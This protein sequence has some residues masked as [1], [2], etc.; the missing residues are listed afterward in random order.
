MACAG[1]CIRN[2]WSPARAWAV[3]VRT[4]RLHV[5]LA[6]WMPADCARPA[7]RRSS[8]ARRTAAGRNTE[9]LA[10]WR[11]FR[12]RVGNWLLGLLAPALL[13]LLAVTWRVQRRGGPGWQLL[14]SDQPWLVAMWHGRMLVGL[15]MAMHRS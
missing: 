13:R 10:R 1:F 14:T 7:A 8:A 12:R 6:A 9:T 2:P 4:I 11:R 15:P 3:P 5:M